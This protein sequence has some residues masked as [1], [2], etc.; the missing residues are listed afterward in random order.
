MHEPRVHGA[1]KT[2][3]VCKKFLTPGSF[4]RHT[5]LCLM[6]SLT[7]SPSQRSPVTPHY[8]PNLEKSNSSSLFA[9]SN[10]LD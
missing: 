5:K 7:G 8:P 3:Q 2:C 9:V 1:R 10:S 4:G 6:E